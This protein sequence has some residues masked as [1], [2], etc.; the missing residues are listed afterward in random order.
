MPGAGAG[1]GTNVFRSS[2]DNAEGQ[3]G[4]TATARHGAQEVVSF[5][6]FPGAPSCSQMASM[7]MV[8]AAG[9]CMMAT[10][11]PAS[12]SSYSLWPLP[13]ECELDWNSDLDLSRGN[14]PTQLEGWGKCN[15]NSICSINLGD[16]S[17]LIN[18]LYLRA[19]S[20][21]SPLTL[22]PTQWRCLRGYQSLVLQ[23]P[24][25]EPFLRAL[26]LPISSLAFPPYLD[27]E[28]E[29]EAGIMSPSLSATENP[30][31]KV[32]AL[33]RMLCRVQP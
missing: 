31:L 32:E 2:L 20:S 19:P 4:W 25:I 6:F 16:Q 24:F 15:K 21:L 11:G 26:V 17:V 22:A 5:S 18:Y 12:W 23:A 14:W 9:K 27:A 10:S 13:L 33:R 3:P 1:A 28:S 8:C 30:P 29:L 7:V